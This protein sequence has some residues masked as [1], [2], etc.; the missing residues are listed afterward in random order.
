[1]SENT[2]IDKK[3]IVNTITA[4]FNTTQGQ[5]TNITLDLNLNND[6]LAKLLFQVDSK[7]LLEKGIF[8]EFYDTNILYDTNND[9]SGI[10]IS[11]RITNKRKEN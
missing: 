4:L 11:V 1:M 7:T 10:G 5:H 2:P 8:L 3:A 6:E 9:A